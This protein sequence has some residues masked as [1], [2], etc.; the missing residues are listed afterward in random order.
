MKKYILLIFLSFSF[1]THAEIVRY[2]SYGNNY[3][4]VEKCSGLKLGDVIE[5]SSLSSLCPSGKSWT[6]GYTYTVQS[7]YFSYPG[8]FVDVSR[9]DGRMLYGS[10]SLSTATCDSPNEINP[11]TG[12]CEEPPEDQCQAGYVYDYNTE[13]CVDDP[14]DDFCGEMFASSYNSCWESNGK[15]NHSAW[16]CDESSH[17]YSYSCDVTDADKCYFGQPSYPDCLG[18]SDNADAPD[19]NYNPD[20]PSSITPDA[21]FEKSEPDAVAP[22]DNTDTAVL[23]AIQNM[24]RDLNNAN[25]QLSADLNNGVA[26]LNMSIDQTN[27]NLD[28]I[29]VL[30]E[31]SYNQDTQARQEALN[32]YGQNL[33]GLSSLNNSVNGVNG[34]LGKLNSDLNNGF[35]NLGES[36]GT[37][38]D[39]LNTTLGEQFGTLG[40]GLADGF[41]SVTD[42]LNNLKDSINGTVS[43]SACD[44]FSCDGSAAA[45]Y[46]AHQAWF[47]EC[48]ASAASL[49]VTEE[50]SNLISD[51]KT[52]GE[53]AFDENG[54]LK[55]FHTDSES[56]M[57]NYL[58]AY[59]T[60]NGFR[61]SA[62]CPEPRTYDLK[63]ARMT[64]DMSPFCSLALVFRAL[65]MAGASIMSLLMFAKHL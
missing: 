34:S 2:S 28:S 58:K 25:S 64:L 43:T 21:P 35:S 31:N 5:S 4:L 40:E 8:F 24:N 55:N 10:I 7:S 45:C 50:G 30:L 29:G 63:I 41:G 60:E 46:L 3:N 42:G 49:N 9:S 65:L 20:S 1:Y 47:D 56:T 13:S 6:D 26:S 62:S 23:A 51:L 16:Q 12:K 11:Q 44:T 19:S 36:V 37:G 27:K 33:A 53:G 59:T 17:D 32:F 22:T 39:S 18:N 52:M 38:F 57:E 48:S 15:F 14:D 61:F 54:A